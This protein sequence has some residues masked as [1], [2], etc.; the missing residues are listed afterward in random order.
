MYVKAD[1]VCEAGW[2]VYVCPAGE[3]LTYRYT[4]EEGGIQVRRYW[5]NKCRTF[6]FRTDCT[7][8]TERRISRWE[9]EYLIDRLTCPNRVVRFQSWCMTGLGATVGVAGE[10]VPGGEAGHVTTS[11][12]GG[13]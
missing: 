2:D 6:P 8:G 12:A 5:I 11:G 9:H 13:R 3:D 4:T 7:T 10:A 1:F